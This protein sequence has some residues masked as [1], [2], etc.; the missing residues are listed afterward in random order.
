[1]SK[2]RRVRL[3]YRVHTQLVTTRRRDGTRISR[4]KSKRGKLRLW[5]DYKI[6]TSNVRAAIKY[7]TSKMMKDHVGGM[8]Y[9][10]P[11]GDGE[12]SGNLYKI[13]QAKW[14]HD[15]QPFVRFDGPLGLYW[16]NTLRKYDPTLIRELAKIVK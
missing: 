7:V 4:G 9:I 8:V 3:T 15:N 6:L 2:G 16:R 5:K 12:P 14:G 11:V 10:E 13:F 1:M